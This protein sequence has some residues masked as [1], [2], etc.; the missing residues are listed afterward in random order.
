MKYLP[1]IN[2]CICVIKRKPVEAL[3]HLRK[4]S[5]LTFEIFPSDEKAA[6]QYG[7]VRTEL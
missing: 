2:I 5:L 4:Q 1:D 3:K 7:V 6:L